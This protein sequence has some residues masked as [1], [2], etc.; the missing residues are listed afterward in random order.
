M[1]THPTPLRTAA[2]G[3]DAARGPGVDRQAASARA[4][5][6]A[7]VRHETDLWNTVE[8]R[9]RGEGVLSL[10]RLEVLRVVEAAPTGARVQ[11]VATGVGTSIAAASRLLDRLAA[12]GLLDR[13]PDAADRRSVR[14]TL[15][16]RGRDA[17]ALADER[18][19]RALSAALGAADADT[20]ALGIAATARLQAALEAGR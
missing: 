14:S 16:P 9:M 13:Q 2:P 11:D 1:S 18:F 5:F 20:V 4:Y 15:S 17:F 6:T 19:E 3:D 12:D 7:L 10:A 8:K